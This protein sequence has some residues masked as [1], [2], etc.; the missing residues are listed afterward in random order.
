[1]VMR[2]LTPCWFLLIATFVFAIGAAPARADFE[3]AV[4]AYE[5]GEYQKA[6]DE[7]SALARDGDARAQSYLGRIDRKLHAGTKTDNSPT[8]RPSNQSGSREPRESGAQPSDWT[9]DITPWNPSEEHSAPL[10]A[11]GIVVPYHASVRSTLFHV[12]ADATVIGLQYV[13]RLFD[14][15]RLY[16]NLQVIS[17]NGDK[18]TLGVLASLWW[19]LALYGLYRLGQILARIMKTAF[20]L[21][22]A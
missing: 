18:L 19:L 3:S 12:P 11:N 16:R 8:S 5:Q 22:G 6:Y 21:V 1:M 13:T 20:H 4:A 10:T 7:F 15:D 17:R 2:S 9:I 14:A